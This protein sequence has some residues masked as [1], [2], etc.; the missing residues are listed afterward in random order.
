MDAIEN[1]RISQREALR[2]SEIADVVSQEKI[3]RWGNLGRDFRYPN[4]GEL[5][6]SSEGDVIKNNNFADYP[7]ILYEASA[8]PSTLPI[9]AYEQVYRE[10]GPEG[11]ANKASG[12]TPMRDGPYGRVVRPTGFNGI[13][14][15]NSK[16]D[17][18]YY[19]AL[20]Q[21]QLNIQKYYEM[22]FDKLRGYRPIG[23]P[24]EIVDGW[25]SVAPTA[26]NLGV[27]EPI[28]VHQAYHF[29]RKADQKRRWYDML[30]S[31]TNAQYDRQLLLQSM[32]KTGKLDN[33]P[34]PELHSNL[35]EEI[36]KARGKLP[37][38]K[39]DFNVSG[40]TPDH[41]YISPYVGYGIPDTAGW[42]NGIFEKLPRKSQTA[43]VPAIEA[44]LDYN[45]QI[46]KIPELKPPLSDYRGRFNKGGHA[47]FVVVPKGLERFVGN[48]VMDAQVNVANA[49]AFSNQYLNNPSFRSATNSYIGEGLGR[50]GKVAGG[51]ML[52]GHALKEGPMDAIV[53][54]TMGPIERISPE[55][56]YGSQAYNEMVN[57]RKNEERKQVLE[58]IAKRRFYEENADS[59]NATRRMYLGQ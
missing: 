2:P 34:I 44:M 7:P 57:A 41:P 37:V 8:N 4:L 29:V 36:R 51:A 16:Q 58:T 12:G 59:I 26:E 42:R 47:G 6:L 48:A 56:E 14:I 5:Y 28:D 24:E 18:A 20:S 15:V 43:L 40:S 13:Q 17:P 50:A 19:Q 38:Q 55:S 25:R 53:T 11:I 1:D 23:V 3:E 35:L 10:L 52:L 31:D 21:Q 30:L 46:Y 49:N 22:Q 54:A 27:P 33:T 32:L 45:K 9:K 39:Y